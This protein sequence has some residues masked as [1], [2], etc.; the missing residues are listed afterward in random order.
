M[1][2]EFQMINEVQK[3]ND[4]DY[5]PW[6][7]TTQQHVE[8]YFSA[9]EEGVSITHTSPKDNAIARMYCQLIQLIKTAISYNSH[10]ATGF[11]F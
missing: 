2:L 7:R 10:F 3:P 4:S 8:Q 11:T 5:A 6:L 1:Y 9:T